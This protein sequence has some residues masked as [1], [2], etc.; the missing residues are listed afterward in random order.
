MLTFLVALFD[1]GFAYSSS[2]KNFEP[3]TNRRIFFKNV[4]CISVAGIVSMSSLDKAVAIGP[5]K[6]MLKPIE[7]TAKICPKDRPIPGKSIFST[8]LD[9]TRFVIN[10]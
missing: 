2:N 9:Q 4:S 5:V 7:Y 6:L 1:Y 10:C 8:R 3:S